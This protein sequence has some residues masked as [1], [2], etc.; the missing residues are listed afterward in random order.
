MQSSDLPFAFEQI[1]EAVRPYPKAA[2]FELAERGYRSPFQQL[3]ACII[4][5]RTYDEVSLPV[6]QQL[7]EQAPTPDAMLQLSVD[8]IDQLI[9]ASTFHEA[10]A[11]QIWEIAHRI[12]HE[13]GGELPC[14]YQTLVSFSGVGP[15]CANLTLGI[16]CSHP[17]ISVDV[18]VH[19]ITNRWGYVHTRTPEQT[20]AALE[21]QLPSL[22]WIT[23]N[24]L[25]V[26]FGKHI[27]TGKLPRCSICPVVD[28][29]EQV[30]VQKNR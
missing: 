7:L 19:R 27:C 22:Y 1:R 29:C 30:G 5:I 9:Q 6:S 17:S 12:V 3:V 4:S 28:K 14:D 15:K 13:Y 10:K 20:L 24:E 8:E 23:I 16:A 18:H 2:M 25:L 11:K 26:P 21:Q